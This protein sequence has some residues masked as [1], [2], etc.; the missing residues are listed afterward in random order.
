MSQHRFECVI[1]GQKVDV[2]MGWDRPLSGFFMVVQ[3]LT[4]N[5]DGEFLYSNL[6]NRVAHPPDMDD[7]LDWLYEHDVQLPAPM[8]EEIEMDAAEDVGNKYVRHSL[9]D[10]EHVR[11]QGAV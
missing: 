8:I 9:V 3:V 1:D 7:Y 10:G 6:N 4:P 5:G 2:L 11:L